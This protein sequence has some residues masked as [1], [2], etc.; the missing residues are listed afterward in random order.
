M[1]DNDVRQMV[2]DL[3]NGVCSYSRKEASDVI[4]NMIFEKVEPLPEKKSNY[5]RWLKRNGNTVFELLEELITV[6]HNEITVESFG[7]LVDVDTFDIGDKK[8]FLIQ[9]DELFKVAIMATG[10]KKVHRQRIYDKKVDTKAFRLGV[11]IYAEMFDFLKGNIDW[12]LF[13]DRVSK[14]FD[15][16]VCTL[17]TKTIFGAYDASGNPNLCKASND[18]ALS[19]TLKEMIAKV[20][21]STGQEV[22][23]LGT[24]TALAHVKS[25]ATF[26]SDAEKDDRRN[27]GYTQVFEGTPLVPLPNYYDKTTGAFEVDDDM[28][29]IVPVGESLVKLGYEGDVQLY[30]DTEGDRQDYQIEMEMNRML[31]LGV[32]IA[33]TY[34]MIKISA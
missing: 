10:V 20:A 1:I 22:Q 30:E 25:D 7:D 18:N 17:V 2:I 15:K 23:I 28:L 16:K 33:S 27:Y 24:K 11:K 21:D 26:V 12:T 5:R 4:R 6:T 31:H 19:T 8:E 3:H 29:L 34:A 32:A 13:V 14:S 9:N